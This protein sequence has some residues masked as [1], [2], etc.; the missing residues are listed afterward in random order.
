M[1]VNFCNER[2]H[3]TLSFLQFHF[4]ILL[5]LMLRSLVF[6]GV[7]VKHLVLTLARIESV[8]VAAVVLQLLKDAGLGVFGPHCLVFH[9]DLIV[10]ALVDQ[11][12]VLIVA[13][14][15]LFASLKLPPGLLFNHSGV[16]IQILALKPDLFELLSKSSLFFSLLFFLLF[17]LAV[18]F[19]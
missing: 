5:L 4:V 12:L 17:D 8:L 19:E 18:H 3:L 7:L 13:N 15:S 16:R 2:I 6:K 14:L 10:R 9:L 1:F 11:P